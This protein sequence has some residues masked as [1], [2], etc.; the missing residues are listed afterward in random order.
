MTDQKGK[1]LYSCFIDFKKAFDSVWHIDL[2]RKLE[3]LGVNGNFLNLIKSIYERTKCAVKV[4]G[5]TTNF[6]NYER[7]VHQGNPISP[8][9]F[10][11]FTNDLFEQLNSTQDISLDKHT[12]TP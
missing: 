12:L 10:N 11:I 5:K 4:N 7:V 2:F 8:L 6:L 9:L 3:N 1:K